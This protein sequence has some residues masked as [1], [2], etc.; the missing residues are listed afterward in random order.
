MQYILFFVWHF[1]FNN[2]FKIYLYCS[3]NQQFIYFYSFVA[4]TLFSHLPADG[5][6]GYFQIGCYEWSYSNILAHIFWWTYIFVSC[7]NTQERK[8]RSWDEHIFNHLRNWVFQS[9]CMIFTLPPAIY[10]DSNA[11]I[12]TST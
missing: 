11:Y 9:G 6:F 2:V 1:S 4:K 5:Y 8:F 3:N 7:G 12:V 10:E